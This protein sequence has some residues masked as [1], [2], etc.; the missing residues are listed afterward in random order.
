M[1]NDYQ[2]TTSTQTNQYVNPS[3]GYYS[4][5]M[6]SGGTYGYNHNPYQGYQCYSCGQWIYGG[7]AHNCYY[8]QQPVQ[9]IIYQQPQPVQ[10]TVPT[11]VADLETK[12]ELEAVKEELK[13]VRKTLEKLMD[14]AVNS[15]EEVRRRDDGGSEDPPTNS[16]GSLASQVRINVTTE[17]TKVL[18]L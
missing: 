6:G 10:I 2:L 16:E 11:P 18:G 8:Y 15:H 14:L 5:G 9:T 1:A 12:Q 17:A 7:C 3:T 4:T 13:E